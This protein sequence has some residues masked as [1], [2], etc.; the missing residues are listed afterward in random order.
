LIVSRPVKKLKNECLIATLLLSNVGRRQV[1]GN[2][3]ALHAFSMSPLK[4][5]ERGEEIGERGVREESK[6]K[7]VV[8]K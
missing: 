5:K 6:R 4:S 3:D 8:R 1:C 7:R 2:I